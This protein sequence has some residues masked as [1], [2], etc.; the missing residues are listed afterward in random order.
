MKRET[1]LFHRL[2]DWSNLE[3]ALCLVLRGKRD[4]RDARAFVENLPE[5]LSAVGERLQSGGGPLGEFREFI[6]RDPKRRLI[7]APCFPDRVLHHA[8]I[9]VCEPAFERW[10]ISQTCAC[11]VGLG[12]PAAIRE[13]RK[14]TNCRRYDLQLDVK[15]YFESVPRR[16]LMGKLERL[17]GEREMLE[18]WWNILDSYHPGWK[19]GM[20]IGAL[21]SQ[22]LANFSLGFL[23]RFIKES[24]RVRGLRAIHGRSGVVGR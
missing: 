3:H 10:L 21:T 14:W 5:S 19:R 13:T 15:H 20:P 16:R 11:R 4:R 17:F 7:S 18:L 2:P 9:N 8:V 24:L 1:G 22:H 12:L 23:D 6:I